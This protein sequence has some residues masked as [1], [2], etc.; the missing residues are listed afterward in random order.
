MNAG[1]PG[2]MRLVVERRLAVIGSQDLLLLLGIGVFFFGAKRLPELS[3][4]LGQALTEFK[5]GMT[6]AAPSAPTAA[7]ADPPKSEA[8]APTK[9]EGSL[10]P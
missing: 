6:A 2:G 9:N 5:K 4:S 10:T 8:T 7:D 1:R 3:R